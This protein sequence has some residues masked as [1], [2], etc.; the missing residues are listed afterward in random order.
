[1]KKVVDYLVITDDEYNYTPGYFT[2]NKWT[3]DGD[4]I[5]FRSKESEGH[6]EDKLS[7]LVRCS[8]S[9]KSVVDVLCEGDLTSSYVVHE[10]M[11]YYCTYKSLNSVNIDTKE[12]KIIFKFEDVRYAMPHITNDG[13]YINLE[14]H[15]EN[16]MANFVRVDLETGDAKIILNKKFI[17]P[18][19]TANHCMICPTNP[20]LV[21]F[22]HE[23]TAEYVTNRMWAYDVKENRMHNIIKQEMTEDGDLG[24]Y[25]GH[26]MW[27][28]DGKGLFFV[29]YPKS[30]LKP[31]GLCYGDYAAGKKEVLFSGYPY[32]HVGVSKDGKYLI[33]DTMRG[34][35]DGTDLSEV[36]LADIKEKT[37][38]VIDVVH[39]NS[40]HPGHP[41]PSMSPDGSKVVYTAV[42]NG[43]ITTKIAYLEDID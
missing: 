8:V 21:F 25:F 39:A 32:W 12:I 29:K 1:M 11:V 9:K 2:A 36:V 6:E 41:H 23:G 13:R 4:I 5:L 26:E 14:G 18:F 20:D 16:G 43:K 22:A 28:P 7:Y 24:E 30:P 10:N 17:S 40:K 19:A 3:K 33:A 27:A 34:V 42:D 15:Q 38:T 37:E 35:F 31:T